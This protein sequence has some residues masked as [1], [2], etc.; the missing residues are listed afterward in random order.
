LLLLALGI[1]AAVARESRR[2]REGDA[3][4]LRQGA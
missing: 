2:H 1:W 3:P 4:E